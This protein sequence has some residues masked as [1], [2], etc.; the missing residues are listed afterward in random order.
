MAARIRSVEAWVAARER[1][2]ETF[3][4]SELVSPAQQAYLRSNYFHVSG[5]PDWMWRQVA[6]L[7]E[8]VC[9]RRAELTTDATMD[10]RVLLYDPDVVLFEELLEPPMFDTNDMPGWSLWIDVIPPRADPR[11]GI[12]AMHGAVVA[13]VPRSCVEDAEYNISV[14]PTKAID[15][16]ER[17]MGHAPHVVEQLRERGLVL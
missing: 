16:V 9:E 2:T 12:V 14:A 3:F 15:W 13:W 10:G 6:T 5:W 1:T 11:L 4:S 8:Q 17:T 7:C